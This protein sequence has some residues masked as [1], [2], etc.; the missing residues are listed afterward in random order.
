MKTEKKIS[1]FTEIKYRFS[2]KKIVLNL[3]EFQFFGW[4]NGQQHI[5]Y[6]RRLPTNEWL[7]ISCLARV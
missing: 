3:F 7:K 4:N 5:C 6:T 2:N 1:S